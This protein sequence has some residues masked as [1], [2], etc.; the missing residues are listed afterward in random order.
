MAMTRIVLVAV[1][2]TVAFAIGACSTAP[3]L[4]EGRPVEEN[5]DRLL[6]EHGVPAMAWALVVDGVVAECGARGVTTAGG[7]D[8][9][10]VNSMFHIG[11][12]TKAMTALLAGI[13]VDRGEIRWDSTVGE[14]LRLG[15]YGVPA[16]YAGITLRQLLSHTSGVP[17]L[18]AQEQWIAHFTSGE[19]GPVQRRRMVN[20]VFELQPDF[21]PGSAVSYSNMGVVVAG[22]MLEVAAGDDWETQMQ[23]RLFGPLGMERAGFGPPAVNGEPGE[24][25]GHANGPVDPTAPGADNPAG[26]GPAGT[27]HA[28]IGDLADYIRVWLNEGAPLISRDTFDVIVTE[29]RDGYALGW[30]LVDVGEDVLLSHDGSNTMFYS[31]M[32]LEPGR[33]VGVVVVANSGGAEEAVHIL[34]DHLLNKT[35]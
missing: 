12:N 19:P 29:V 28:S 31:T 21:E 25:W 13:C 7:T 2:V 24:P 15:G 20:E 3:A 32:Q 8:P 14:V 4:D 34:A 35:R 27:V 6:T 33:D 22:A 17:T 11:S 10:T 30:L 5:V 9:V 26:L 16:A 1:I 18:M 23:A